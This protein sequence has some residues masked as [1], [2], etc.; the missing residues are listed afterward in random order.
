MTN[1]FS[2]NNPTLLINDN[3]TTSEKDEQQGYMQILS[4]CMTGIRNPRAH[5][6]D[7][8]DSEETALKL[9]V[10]ADQLLQKV[11]SSHKA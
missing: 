7:W 4:G 2:V 1:V 8:E 6:S 3:I 11:N 5:K 9:L 10:L